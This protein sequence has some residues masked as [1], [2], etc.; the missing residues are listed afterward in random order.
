MISMCMMAIIACEDGAKS[1]VLSR[2]SSACC[3]FLPCAR[4]KTR[5][6][7]GRIGSNRSPR[8]RGQTDKACKV[9]VRKRIGEWVGRQVG[10]EDLDGRWKGVPH[11]CRR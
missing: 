7:K 6:K 8:S 4:C 11:A 5:S 10:M 1:R 2:I 9:R 3:F